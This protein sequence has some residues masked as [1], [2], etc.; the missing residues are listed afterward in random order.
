MFT[1]NCH[2]SACQKISGAPYVS[3]L[4]VPVAA[5]QIRGEVR[6]AARH[7]D[8]GQVV[9]D[10]FCAEC[11]SRMFSFAASLEASVGLFA[12]S[13]DDQSWYRPQFNIY[14]SRAPHWHNVDRTLPSF[15]TVP[16]PRDVQNLIVRGVN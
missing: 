16:S 12:T 10:G 6:K 9:E 8:S 5:L 7:G 15:D 3:A 11:G 4:R 14:V 13:L 2:C 1:V